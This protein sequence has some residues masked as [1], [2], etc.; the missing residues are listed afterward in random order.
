[1]EEMLMKKTDRKNPNFHFILNDVKLEALAR[2]LIYFLLLELLCSEL[3][4]GTDIRDYRM[5][6]ESA[7]KTLLI[8]AYIYITPIVLP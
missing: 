7:K 3:P 2:D 6:P 5:V 1:M 8:L 4:A